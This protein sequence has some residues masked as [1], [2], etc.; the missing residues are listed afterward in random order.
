[1]KRI[2][3][4]PIEQAP[5]SARI[6]DCCLANSTAYQVVIEFANFL[7]TLPQESDLLAEN[8]FQS[9]RVTVNLLEKS[10]LEDFS[11][12]ESNGWRVG[13]QDRCFP[14]WTLQST[15]RNISRC[16]CWFIKAFP[17]NTDLRPIDTIPLFLKQ[18]E[19]WSPSTRGLGSPMCCMLIAKENGTAFDGSMGEREFRYF[20]RSRDAMPNPRSRESDLQC[21]STHAHLGHV[22]LS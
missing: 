17:S 13:E 21:Q 9:L 16:L 12:S 20:K 3:S 22:N 10:L 19:N 1:M 15:W 18:H 8:A 6:E 4:V 7:R 14:S 11:T 5:Q 2:Y